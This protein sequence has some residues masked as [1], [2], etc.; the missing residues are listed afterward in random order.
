MSNSN[1][2]IDPANNNSLVGTI[3]FAFSKL[4]QQVNG[5]L[6]AQVIAYDRETN[7]V[8]VQLLIT[9]VGTDGSQTPRPQIATL[10]VMVMGGGGFTLSFPLKEGDFGWV[11]AN[12]RD[13][14]L[15]LQNYQ[16]SP[17]NTNRV[18]NF[19]DGLF[20]P[21]SMKTLDVT[22][23]NMNAITLKNSDGSISITIGENP[24]NGNVQ[25][26]KIVAQ[27]IAI[28]VGITGFVTI[29]GNVDVQGNI[30]ATGAITPATPIIPFPPLYPP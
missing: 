4:L 17:P 2:S 10:P 18:K 19:S 25:E 5:M 20:I 24:S 13:I 28:D 14:S 22:S 8:Q 7:R 30:I 11:L 6:P 3:S 27:R 21:D 9:I 29:N 12:D 23:D 26:V 1:P 15:F 16:Q